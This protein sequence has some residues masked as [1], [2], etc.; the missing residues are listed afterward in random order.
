MNWSKAVQNSVFIAILIILLVIVGRLFAPFFTVLLWSTLLYILLSPLHQRVIKRIKT[1]GIKGMIL[2]NIWAGVFSLGTVI[3]ILIPL[4]FVAAQFFRQITELIRLARDTFN[5][6]PEIIRDIL[7]KISE[8]IRDVTSDQLIISADEIQRRIVA[9]LSS[10]L[11]NLIQ[12]SSSI[13]RNVG[14]F[15]LG[16]ILM[17]FSLFFFYMDG[18]YLSR[19]VL[20]AVPIRQEHI[21]ALVGKFKDITRNLFFGYIMVALVQA[22]MAYIVFI[23]FRVKGALVFAGLTLICAFI[24]MFGA[25]LVWLPI[26]VIRILNGEIFKGIVFLI[27]S[28]FFISTLDNFLRPMF[29]QDRIQLHPLIIFFAIMGGVI[30]FGFNGIIVGPMVVIFFLTVLDLFLTEHMIKPD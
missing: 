14:S 30:V 5:H 12:M 26:G 16:L 13:A 1:S 15:L 19:L 20:H 4:F 3:L 29:L 2:K 22:I 28:G 8:F 21:T 11:Q 7:E 24:P 23:I 10:S 17:I 25:G 27:I 6:N 9:Y 18:A